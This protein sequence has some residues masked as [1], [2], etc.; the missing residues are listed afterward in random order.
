MLSQYPRFND[1]FQVYEILRSF[2]PYGLQ[3]GNYPPLGYWLV[4]PLAWLNEYA[5][6]MIMIGLA[7][8]FVV[9]WS[10]RSFTPG[11]SM[12]SKIL[13]VGVILFSLPVTVAVDR[14]NVD[15]VVF[16]FV[17]IGIAALE[18]SRSALAATW[19]GLAAAA[20]LFPVAY[21][22]LF[23]RGRRLRYLL[24]GVA[25]A[26]GV[27]VVGFL[28]FRGNFVKNFDEFWSSSTALNSHSPGADV[29]AT[30][31]NASLAAWLQAIGEAFGGI[32]GLDVVRHAVSGLVVPAEVVAGVALAAYLRWREQSLWRAVTLIT[33]YFLLFGQLS[34]YYE[35]LFLL[36]ALSLFVKHAAADRSGLVI[37]V[38]FGLSMAPRAYFYFGDTSID[39][40]VLT[41]APLLLALSVAVYCN[42]RQE[43]LEAREIARSSEADRVLISSTSRPSPAH[44]RRDGGGADVVQRQHD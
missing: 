2:N 38:L 33:T 44:P 24:L 8:G 43:R 4:A 3:Q 37:A 1:F 40:S 27:T 18:R 22:L 16:V 42:G 9:W 39:T 14:A 13:V 6:L 20:K 19:L 12:S 35:L 26:A 31:Y 36:V 32:H 41:T 17:V 23:L 28:S 25:V 7:V 29:S 10:Y 15:L 5:A 21:L 34:Y 30:N 11:L